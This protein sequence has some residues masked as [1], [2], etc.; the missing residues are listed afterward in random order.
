MFE[1]GPFGRELLADVQGDARYLAAVPVAPVALEVEQ[2]RGGICS[3]VALISCRQS[4]SGCSR[5]THSCTWACRARMP[6]DVPGGDFHGVW[7]CV[8]ATSSRCGL[9]GRGR[10]D[11]AQIQERRPPTRRTR[12]GRVR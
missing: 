6:F 12:V 1:D 10:A 8:A 9:A 3:G 5:S 7:W 4:T 11:V 2:H